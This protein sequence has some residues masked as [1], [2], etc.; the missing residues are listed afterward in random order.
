MLSLT[1]NLNALTRL[2]SNT[3]S[4]RFNNPL[5][6]R[7]T[8]RYTNQYDNKAKHSPI[9]SWVASSMESG[10]QSQKLLGQALQNSSPNKVR[11]GVQ[12][13]LVRELKQ[14]KTQINQLRSKN[15]NQI[16]SNTLVL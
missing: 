15:S 3:E 5:T 14:Q 16:E 12:N 4:I 8:N 9:K 13:V 6:P 7:T 1:C 10:I 2:R 11:Q